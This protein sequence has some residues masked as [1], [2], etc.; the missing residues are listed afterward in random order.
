MMAEYEYLF[1]IGLQKRLR[2]KIVGNIYVKVNE[3]DQ[4]VVNIRLEQENINFIWKLDNI[5]DKILRGHCSDELAYQVLKTYRSFITHRFFK[6][7]SS[8]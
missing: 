6:M 2:E 7:E 4:L 3:D 5:S 1:S 8:N